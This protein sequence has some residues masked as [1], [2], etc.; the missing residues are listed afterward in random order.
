MSSLTPFCP[1]S[2]WAAFQADLRKYTT[3]RGIQE[4]TL[5]TGGY[6]KIHYLQGDTSKIHY[7]R[8]KTKILQGDSEQTYYRE[9][10]NKH[11]TGWF[12]TNILQGDS[13]KNTTGRFRKNTT[14]RFRKNTTGRFR[15]NTTGR[16]KRKYTT[17]RYRKY[18]L[19]GDTENINYRK[20]Q[21][22]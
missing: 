10:Q 16:P 6:R 4:N 5:P 15:K 2:T 8:I 3:Y 12:R 22:I 13:E 17:W 9:I 21:K 14:G 20:I 18:K 19:Q 7:R 11:T 1:F